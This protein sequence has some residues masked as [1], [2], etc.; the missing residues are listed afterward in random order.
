MKVTKVEFIHFMSS[1]KSP[2][3]ENGLNKVFLRLFGGC[4]LM[5]D[6]LLCKTRRNTKLHKFVYF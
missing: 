4:A 1:Q 5:C 3:S 6:W 2:L